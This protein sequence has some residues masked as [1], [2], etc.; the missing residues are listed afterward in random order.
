MKISFLFAITFLA[1]INA[2]FAQQLIFFNY[3]VLETNNTAY[4]ARIS[5]S[6]AFTIPVL[7]SGASYSSL[8]VKAGNNTADINGIHGCAYQVIGSFPICN[9]AFFDLNSKYKQGNDYFNFETNFASSYMAS[10]FK[11]IDEIDPNG[12]V[13]RSESMNLYGWSITNISSAGAPVKFAVFS[14]GKLGIDKLRIE[15]TFVLPQQLVQLGVVNTNVG[16]IV[17]PMGLEIL[18]AIDASEYNYKSSNNH[19]RLVNYVLTGST[20][21]RGSVNTQTNG[22]VGIVSSGSGNTAVSFRSVK[23]CSIGFGANSNSKSVDVSFSSETDVNVLNSSELVAQVKGT[24]SSKFG[25]T[26][27][28]T[29]FPP[30]ADYIFY[31][32]TLTV[33]SDPA[34][35]SSSST[36][37]FSFFLLLVLSLLF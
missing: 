19:L 23:T 18:I 37:F 29:N 22:N 24:Y 27:I 21:I 36:I 20:K 31:D 13:V 34:V 8:G 7:A 4:S 30:G 2:S 10:L 9:L 1:I 5:S 35:T 32:P 16:T 28:Y 17:S 6:T 33:G 12:N 15:L 3:K 26:R 11:S 14:G 25:L